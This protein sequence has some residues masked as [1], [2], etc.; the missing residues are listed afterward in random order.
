MDELILLTDGSWDTR[1]KVGFGAYLLI[2]DMGLSM[3]DYKN[4]VK[5]KRFEQTSS[6]TLELGTLL[7]AFSEIKPP[8]CTLKIYTDSQNIIRLPERRTSLEQNNYRTGKNTPV[9]NQKLYREFYE[10]T[11]KFDCVFEKVQGHKQSKQKDEI[12]ILFA[13]VDR[14]SRK[15]LR[16]ANSRENLDKTKK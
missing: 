1:T 13:L 14:A 15:A 5:L 16:N 4:L 11:G 3:N 10:M 7:W 9:N 8:G 6:V 2:S 12:D